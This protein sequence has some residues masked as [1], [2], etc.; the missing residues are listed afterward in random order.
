MI[1]NALYCPN[2]LVQQPGTSS[3]HVVKEYVCCRKCYKSFQW[4]DYLTAPF[5][6]ADSY[7]KLMDESIQP[8][9]AAAKI[10]PVWSWKYLT[11][12]WWLWR[13]SE[14]MR[15]RGKTMTDAEFKRWV[16]RAMRQPGRLPFDEEF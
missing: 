14:P 11:T 9:I 6:Q 4:G 15:A 13:T 2:C 1:H 12:A 3:D 7:G 10:P 8:F 5:P 16:D